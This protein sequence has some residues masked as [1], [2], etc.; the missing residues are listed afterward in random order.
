MGAFAGA[1]LIAVTLIFLS[2]QVR[3]NTRALNTHSRQATLSCSTSELL[4]AVEHPDSPR[5][6]ARCV[7][8]LS[9]EENIKVNFWLTA[10]MRSREFAW[11]QFRD[12]NIDEMQWHQE[13]MVIQA[14]L[15]TAV[16]RT[17]RINEGRTVVAQHELAGAARILQA[18]E[19]DG[20]A[21]N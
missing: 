5:N 3:Q 6:A 10:V 4:A 9:P 1:I 16:N 13:V 12:G 17:G 15:N 18:D 21:R 11:L 20:L 14:I 7:N 8:E 19:L 2:V